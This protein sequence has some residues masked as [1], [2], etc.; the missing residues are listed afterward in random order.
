M[1]ADGSL[2]RVAESERPELAFDWHNPDYRPIMQAR[3]DRLS[4]MRAHPRHVQ[5]LRVYYRHNPADFIDD[6]GCTMDPRNVARGVPPFL[7]FLL[8]PKQREMIEWIMA[9]WRAGEP[10][11]IEKSRDVGASWIAMALGCTLCMLENSMMIGIGS[12]KEMKLDRP[13]DPDTLFYKARS[14]V[15]SVPEEFRAGWTREKHSPYMRM[16]FPHTGSSITGEAGDGIGRGGRKTIFFVDEAA[17]LEHPLSVDGA[18]VATTECRI[19]MSSVSIEGMKNAFAQRR[20]SGQV[21]VFTMHWRDDLR[22][23]DAWAETKRKSVDSMVWNSE[24]DLNY[25]AAAEGVIIPPEWVQCAID[26]HV[27]IKLTPSGLK[28]GALDV[29]DQGRDVNAFAARHGVL[30]THC[31]SWS[32]SGSD[33]FATAERAFLLCDELGLDGYDYDADGLGAGIRGDSSRIASR[34]ASQ[35]LRRVRVGEFRGSAG[36]LDPERKVAGTDRTALD[37]FQNLKAQSWWAL[38]QRFQETYRAV[39]GQPY[40]ADA[41]ISLSGT[42][43]DLAKLSLELSQPQWKLSL[44]GKMQVDKVPDGVASPNLADAVMMLF[45]A[46]RG[47]MRIN[48]DIFTME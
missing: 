7:P 41:I 20:H 39:N 30:V 34:R 43:P 22:K 21:K 29:A 16:L 14:F 13:G 11:L 28:R 10:G 46:R 1:A 19:D 37:F 23:D 33:L 2:A 26:A 42:I 8:M 31:S 45:A 17:H 27:K 47:P 40:A 15:E 12:A 32:G 3:L 25:T 38:R 9:R 5:S 6:W 4:W 48:P 35:N 44:S 36:V 18:L 24:Y